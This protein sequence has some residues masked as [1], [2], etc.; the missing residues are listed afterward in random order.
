MPSTRLRSAVLL[1]AFALSL[2]V[3][4]AQDT[5]D[6]SSPAGLSMLVLFMGIAAI[7]AVF[8]IRWSQST[9]EED[10]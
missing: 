3:A 9:Q 4:S 6:P 5:A 7:V 10:D 8:A 1:A 2:G